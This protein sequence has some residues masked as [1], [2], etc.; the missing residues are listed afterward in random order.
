MALTK[1]RQIELSKMIHTALAAKKLDTRGLLKFI[2]DKTQE[3]MY[4]YLLTVQ[5]Q[6]LEEQQ[7]FLKETL[8]EIVE[9]LEEES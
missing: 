6:A 5:K 1:K 9:K 4:K 7:E 3:D 8:D 2:P